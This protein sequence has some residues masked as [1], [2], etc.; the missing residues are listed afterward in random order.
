ME[1]NLTENRK[2]LLLGAGFVARPTVD[3]LTKAGI[4]VTIGMNRLFLLRMQLKLI[5]VQ[6]CRTVENA[7]K[8]C[9]KTKNTICISLDVFNESDLETAIEKV[10]LVVS[11]I[12]YSHHATVAKAAI[13][14]KKNMVTTSY[15]S[16]ALAELEESIK[17]AGITVMNEIGLD[18]GI[19]HLYAIKTIDEVHREGGKILSFVSYCGG[20][21]AP[22]K[23]TILSIY[24]RLT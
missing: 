17:K 6:A 15:I 23:S 9:K 21:P 7:K 24:H 4:E 3:I 1:Q 18:P 12:P 22:G 14:K 5:C 19:D 2:V 8:L 20:L 13:K 16:P 11:L 10:D